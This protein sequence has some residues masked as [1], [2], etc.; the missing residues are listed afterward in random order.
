MIPDSNNNYRMRDGLLNEEEIMLLIDP[1]IPDT[2]GDTIGDEIE[3][4][5]ICLNPLN[6]DSK[7]M[8]MR[9][10]VINSTGIDSDHD[11]LTNVREIS[12]ERNPCK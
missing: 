5:Y 9:G 12:Q 7:V 10:D 2:D 1:T 8:N 11:G 4:L 3:S 6:D